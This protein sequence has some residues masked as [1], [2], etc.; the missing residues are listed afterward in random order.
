MG[1]TYHHLIGYQQK[2]RVIISEVCFY[3]THQQIKNGV[4]DFIKMNCAVADALSDLECGRA[5]T[6][7]SEGQC[8][9]GICGTWHGIQLQLDM[10]N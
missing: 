4:G 9:T 2:M 5:R 3:T 6:A 10:V 1:P 8:T 7:R